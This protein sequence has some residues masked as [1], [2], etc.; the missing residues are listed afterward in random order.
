MAQL[1]VRREVAAPAATVWRALVDWPAH[2]RWTPLTSVRTTSGRPDGVGA[3]FVARTG[4]GRLGFDDPMTVTQWNP[5][6]AG[7]VGR[8]TVRKTGR[9]VH[10]GATFSVTPRDSG[11]L[12]QWVEEVSVTGVR[13]WPFG[14]TA[15]RLVGRLVFG[16]VLA[17][18]AR[19]VESAERRPGR[20]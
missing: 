5:P 16:R 1:T 4:L 14:R 20:R 17:R 15:S 10:G 11:C 18:M 7:G 12:V 6:T 2:G 19:E 8:C 3:Q 9:V 13:R